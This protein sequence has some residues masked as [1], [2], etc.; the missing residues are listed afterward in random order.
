VIFIKPTEVFHSIIVASFGFKNKIFYK[1]TITTNGGAGGV[2]K[3]KD[4][5][6][7]ERKKRSELALRLSL[8]ALCA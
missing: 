7:C 2:N 1:N 5:D 3:Q 8:Q 4:V 6:N